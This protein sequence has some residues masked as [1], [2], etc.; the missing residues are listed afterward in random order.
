MHNC[1]M[2]GCLSGKAYSSFFINIFIIC[3]INLYK[4]SITLCA[5][6]INPLAML[7][8]WRKSEAVHHQSAGSIRFCYLNQVSSHFNLIHPPLPP[9]SRSPS[10]PLP[11]LLSLLFS[12]KENYTASRCAKWFWQPRL[13]H[14]SNHCLFHLRD[15]TFTTLHL[16]SKA[17]IKHSFIMLVWVLE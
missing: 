16:I 1:S 11:H 8:V 3:F 2:A 9:T 5:A 13:T 17:D 4:W 14:S 15:Q 6:R 10:P 7:I 12:E